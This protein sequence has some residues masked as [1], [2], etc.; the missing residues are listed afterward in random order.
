VFNVLLFIDAPFGRFTPAK[1][2]ILLVDGI[3][4][5]IV[6]ELVSPA[7]FLYTYVHSPLSK[8]SYG[9]PPSFALSNPANVFTSLFLIHYLNR[10]LVS[11][12]RTPSRS[13]AHIIVP[14]CGAFFN[15]IN[16]SLMAAYL[17]SPSAISFLSR[18]YSRPI[19]WIGV[20]M[21]ALGFVGNIV[22]DEILFNIRRKANAKGKSKDKTKGPQKEHYS[23]PHGLLYKYISYP[24][25]FCEWIEWLGFALACSP[26]PDLSSGSAFLATVSPPFLFFLS[27]IF[28]MA[29]RAIK[30]HLWYK[31][32][33]PDYPKERKAV[34]PFLF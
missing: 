30:G 11:P 5:W 14:L 2:S 20:V 10:A 22:H 4:A 18:A 25:Y 32:R 21:W 26:L 15:T 24:N 27:E 19:F 9:S 13:K 31:S 6:M 8:L 33:F 34:V 3:K 12:L 1:D 23:I 28:L 16:G 29:P 7:F 17:S